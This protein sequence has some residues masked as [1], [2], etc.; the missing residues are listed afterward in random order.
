MTPTELRRS[1]NYRNGGEALLADRC[2]NC[3][4]HYH[5]KMTLRCRGPL[6][7]NPV[8]MMKVCDNYK[9]ADHE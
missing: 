7:N 4:H 2:V 1:V 8:S 5:G 9:E 6:K 3:G